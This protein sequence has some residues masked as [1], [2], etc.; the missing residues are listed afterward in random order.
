M[1]RQKP[2]LIRR[3]RAVLTLAPI[4]QHFTAQTMS[5]WLSFIFEGHP[6]A[7]EPQIIHGRRL[8]LVRVNRH[9][10]VCQ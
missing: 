3:H 7:P 4:A 2:S 8:A 6:S 1:L 5:E 9:S 10:T